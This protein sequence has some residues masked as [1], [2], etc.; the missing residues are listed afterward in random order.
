MIVPANRCSNIS[1][2]L[3]LANSIAEIENITTPAL[4]DVAMIITDGDFDVWVLV[5]PD[6]ADDP[7]G[8]DVLTSK[9]CGVWAKSNQTANPVAFGADPTGV[10]DSTEAINEAMASAFSQGAN[11]TDAS[12]IGRLITFPAGIFRMASSGLMQSDR[13]IIQ[14]QPGGATTI[15]TDGA[16]PAFIASPGTLQ[17][18]YGPGFR[19]IRFQSLITS[20]DV[21][22]AAIKFNAA[23]QFFVENCTFDLRTQYGIW[24]VDSIAGH[25]D[26]SY[27]NTGL[28]A[29]QGMQ[30]GIFS[31]VTNNASV[32]TGANNVTIKRCVIQR[33]TTAGI[34]LLGQPIHDPPTSIRR[35]AGGIALIDN[36]I[37][38][39]Y[40]DGI[41]LLRNRAARIQ[42]NWLED[43]GADGAS[44]HGHIMDLATGWDESFSAPANSGLNASL[45]ISQNEFAGN[46]NAHADFKQIDL[47][48]SVCPLIEQN[49]FHVT[50]PIGILSNCRGLTIRNNWS[51]SGEPTLSGTLPNSCEIHDNF[52]GPTSAVTTPRRWTGGLCDYTATVRPLTLTNELDTTPTII[53]STVGRVRFFVLNYAVPTSI[54]FFDDPK[55]GDYLTILFANSNTTIVH[56]T[57]NAI[58]LKGNINW[59][60]PIRSMLTLRYIDSNGFT[61]RWIEVSRTEP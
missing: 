5:G 48:F 39:N 22:S 51:T 55:E 14:G 38:H 9:G 3:Y 44:G 2:K 23:E 52:N 10:A 34:A 4:G 45:F 17:K 15:I 11:H 19:D 27:F 35:Q 54:T 20:R 49:V 53:D 50:N 57:N 13:I 21:G 6:D 24:I 33:T 30:Y 37:E 26:K 29:I 56:G 36:Q 32:A 42:G 25:I 41:Q 47:K 1:A 12:Q 8:F 60:A 40:G 58:S 61:N 7:N 59:N 18:I 31:E 16:F 43:N 46:D 28:W